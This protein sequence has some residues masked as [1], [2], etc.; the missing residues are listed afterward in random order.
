MFVMPDTPAMAAE[1]LIQLQQLVPVLQALTH[2]SWGLLGVT[3]MD[4]GAADVL[5]LV[6]LCQGCTQLEFCHGSVTPSL[7][8]WHQLVQ[9]MPTVTNVVFKH[10]EESTSLAMHESLQ[11]MAEQ[12]WASPSPSPAAL[13]AAAI[14]SM[15]RVPPNAPVKA[16]PAARAPIPRLSLPAGLVDDVVRRAVQLG[17]GGALSLTCRTFSQTNL[18]HATA[19]RIQLDTH[20]C[21]QLLTSRVVA[22]LSART[23]RFA[24]I[25]VQP[26]AL[27]SGHYMRM[28]HDVLN[29]LSSC[30]AAETCEL[31]SLDTSDAE[32]VLPLDC[33]DLAQHLID[34]IPRLTSLALHGYS[35]PCSSLAALLSHQRLSLQLQ[36]LDLTGSTI[37]QPKR[38]E[39]GA[40]TLANLFHG[41]RLQH[42]SLDVGAEVLMP[43]LQPLAQHL[44]QL[45]VQLL[46]QLY[47]T[48]TSL[49]AA[50]GPLQQL[51][52]LTVS[53]QCFLTNPP[54]VLR[55]FP[56]LHTLQL[57]GVTLYGQEQ[58][59]ALLAATQ[60]TSVQLNSVQDLSSS[61]ADAP[62]SWQRLELTHWIDSSTAAYLPL[63]SLTQ[64]L[65]L[66]GLSVGMG[67]D[68]DGDVGEDGGDPSLLVAAAVHNLTQ[69]CKVPVTIKA[70]KLDCA[71]RAQLAQFEAMLQPL[72]CCGL[73]EVVFSGMQGVS[74]ADV[75]ALAALCQ[76][77]TR[78]QFSMCS[79]IPSLQFWR[80]L[81]QLM[82]SVT[83][84][85]CWASEG[86]ATAA[87][88]RSLRLMVKQ[89]WSRILQVCIKQPSGPPTLPACWKHK[90]PSQPGKL[91]RDMQ[92]QAT[93]DSGVS[94]TD[95][96]SPAGEVPPPA[97]RLLDLPP[98]LLDDIACRV[99]QL[100]A[101]SLLPLT[102]CAFSQARLLHVPAL[103]IQ[104]GRQSC[105]QLLTPR[106]VAALQARTSK[107]ALT[108]EQPETVDSRWFSDQLAPTLQL[109]QTEYTQD[110]TDL[111]AHALA[112][113]G[114]CAAVEV[115]SLVSSG[116]YT[117]NKRRYLHCPPGL[118]QH[119]L[120]SFP[121]LTALTLQGLCVS[122]NELA[123]L[124]SHSSLA[125]QLQRLHL[126]DISFQDGDEGAV[127]LTFQGLQLKQLSIAF[128]YPG[129]RDTLLLP[130]FQPLAQHLTQLHLARCKGVNNDLSDFIEYLQ[131]L[132]QLQVLTISHLDGLEGLAELL[133]ALP[134]L[135]TLQ[136]PEVNVTEQE[137]ITL[138]AATQITS[139]QLRQVNAL[140]TSYADAPC[141]WQRLELT[142]TIAW[143]AITY[144][145]LHSLSQPLV[146]GHLLISEEDISDPE[147]AAAIHLLAYA[148]KVP[149]QIKNV[150]LW[151]PSEKKLRTGP[152]VLAPTIVQQQRV[153]LAQLVAM[154]Q[155]LQCCCSDNVSVVH[156]HEVT[157]AD[158]LALAPLCRDCTHFELH[159][160]SVEPS[161]GYYQVGPLQAWHATVT[162]CSLAHPPMIRVSPRRIA[163]GF[164]QVT[165]DGGASAT[166]G[167]S[168]A[169]EAPPPATRLLD[170]PPAL[171]DDIACRVMQLGA[172]SLLLLTC[173]AFSQARLLYVP[174][175]H[176]QLGRQCCDQLLTPR[177][178]AALQARTSKLALTLWQ[179]KTEDSECYID[180]LAHTLPKLDNCAAVEPQVLNCLNIN[181][182]DISNP[183]VAAALRNMAYACKVPV[184]IKSMRLY[185]LTAEE[186]RC[187][188]ITPALLQQQR[189]DLAQLVAWQQPLQCCGEHQVTVDGG[190]SAT[191]GYSPAGEAPPPATRLLDLPP[192]LLDDI[193]CRV[194][195]LGARNLLPLTCRAFSQARLLYVPA[196]R[197]Q[198]GRQS[199]DQLLTPR[200][201]AALQ[202]RTSKL[203]L[204]LW[205]P[206]HTRWYEEEYAPTLQ[207]QKIEYTQHYTEQLAYALAKLDNC[208]AVEVCKLV[209]SVKYESNNRKHLCCSPGLA[210]QLLDSFPSLTALT[211]EGLCV[212]NDALASLLSHPPLA[213]QL[214]QL[215]LTHIFFQNGEELGAVGSVF[216]GL[217]LQQL[218]IAVEHREQPGSPLLPSFQPLAQH[219][220][221]LHLV[222]QSGLTTLS[223]FMEYLQPLAQLQVLTMSYHGPDGLHGLEG[224]PRLLQALPL[225]HTLQLPI[226]DV[227]CQH[228]LDTLLAATQLTSLQLYTFEA[229][230]T[231]YADVPCSWQ[232]LELTGC[233]GWKALTYL[234]LH[235]LSQPLVL[236]L[237]HIRV[238]DISDPEVAAAIHLLAYAIKVPVQIKVVQLIMLSREQL[239]TRPRVITPTIVQQQRVDLAQLVAMLQPLQRCFVDKVEVRDLY[240]VT[241]VDVL[242]LAPLCRDCTH[243]VLDGGSIEPSLGF[244]HH[245]VQLMP[246]VQQVEYNG[247]AWSPTPWS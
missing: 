113:L 93:V 2:C 150:L 224:L 67:D 89:P 198:L 78:L 71:H 76:G 133:Q 84:I 155:P 241:A 148:C 35:I 16:Y 196:L 187:G 38:P 240:G 87:M 111:L 162:T 243:F 34:S 177:V 151:V 136:L 41:V 140:D 83:H 112:K 191:D 72:R 183:E 175:L 52:V 124:L 204:T 218:S 59:D 173:R 13:R 229:L 192:A 70:L 123:S 99:M 100:G 200:V 202:A 181:V 199:C 170:L 8:F 43:G 40:V 189:V 119:L 53:R 7:E 164:H 12:P 188:V 60:L 63:H 212:S 32:V 174:A 91:R 80:Q 126:T 69:A 130:S 56:R 186:Q 31:V 213:L 137:L 36:Q 85:T 82:P 141:S 51:Q 120:G 92:Y 184:K 147:V 237:L 201:V 134:Q 29:R 106:V 101:R 214:Q 163:L 167:Y 9:R 30:A 234:P 210:Q 144:L 129:Q 74:A 154:L 115:C 231:T 107:L 108:L 116:Q 96:Y 152:T 215:H 194:M 179:P 233:D 221:Q 139:L 45:H 4:L 50:L 209:C 208:A 135:H 77:C 235:S 138:L 131:P 11:L 145:P 28:L 73:Q 61:R 33:M 5:T 79:L 149:V 246:A 103:H 128:E 203:A 20:R 239:R 205:Q 14:M 247:H 19:F 161:L 160:G 1:Q 109:L 142:F 42:L 90:T 24:L 88:L 232:R 104:L 193:A 127:G 153:D 159:D 158:V 114:N 180:L 62:C 190:I 146:L 219:L 172:R 26:H 223:A 168:P 97:T 166:D 86:V 182:E 47:P 165:V 225:L 3:H 10:V 125:L 222:N 169:G 23:R 171:L 110:Y 122:S 64:P 117:G 25:L 238:E 66:G 98:A 95:G 54:E 230:D 57:P 6:P 15:R 49:A 220:T 105:D 195:Q 143:K 176:I 94:A 242:A 216:E 58:L 55:A 39:S 48:L 227:R 226:F 102:C 178:V 206:V 118:A 68:G 81:V 22:A 228:Q 46:M 65:L 37:T 197:I 121:S 18:L 244:W 207:L 217:Q 44:T 17:A 132:A 156:L 157:A 21:N 75:P 245:L 211:L 236:G 185:M 27:G